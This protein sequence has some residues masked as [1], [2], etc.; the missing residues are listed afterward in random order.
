[1]AL[2]T[3]GST[4]M[5]VA[6]GLSRAYAGM[7][8]SSTFVLS[9]N[10][11]HRPP[12]HA[13]AVF[14]DFTERCPREWFSRR[15]LATDV[16]MGTVGRIRPFYGR[17]YDP[18]VQAVC[19]ADQ[20]GTVLLYEGH[21][22]AASLP[23]WQAVRSTHEL[24]LYV[25]NPPS[26]SYGRRELARL[27]DGADRVIFVADHLRRSVERRL[28]TRSATHFETVH[29]GI[30]PE[31]ALDVR[32][33]P[34]G[35]FLVLFFGRIAE[36][37]GVHLV[38]EAADQ[39]HRHRGRSLRVKVVGSAQYDADSHLSP[40]EIQ[41]REQA[42][43]LSVPVDFVPFVT[44]PDMVRLLS[45][46]G[47]ACLLSTVA[48]GFPLT[49]L[50]AMASGVPV[51]CSDSPGMVEAAGTAAT[52]V[53]RGD[54]TAAADALTTLATDDGLW[55]GRSA[56]GIRRARGFGWEHAMRAIATPTSRA[57]A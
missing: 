37:K 53:P 14:V 29:N 1:M 35:E 5:T 7:G 21:Y 46:A 48:E 38:L 28:G 6:A 50:E 10:R 18:A 51:I 3:P 12:D 34:D 44:R 32:T 36:N 56:A 41:L 17:I 11:G 4:L 54:V 16:A 13:D 52:V 27:L 43:R 15:E 57:G 40:Y 19:D 26:R 31:F 39:A 2:S 9:H 25:H 49:V 23:A 55:S 45:T 30:Q 20:G 8:G 22:A 24:C 42:E 33:P 47:V